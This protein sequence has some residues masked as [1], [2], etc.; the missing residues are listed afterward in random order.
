MKESEKIFRQNQDGSFDY[1]QED[2]EVLHYDNIEDFIVCL[3]NNKLQLNENMMY[4]RDELKE[5][6]ELIRRLN[7]VIV[8]LKS[9]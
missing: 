9:K 6:K 8:E 2:G 5:A 4:F 1:L 3:H 7:N